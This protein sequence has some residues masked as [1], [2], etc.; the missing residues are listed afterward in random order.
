[1]DLVQTYNK[2]KKGRF[3]P[4][5]KGTTYVRRNTLYLFGIAR[6]IADREN[7]SSQTIIANTYTL[8]KEEHFEEHKVMV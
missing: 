7:I 3:Q 2:R 1:M 5:E 6:N 4:T 8:A